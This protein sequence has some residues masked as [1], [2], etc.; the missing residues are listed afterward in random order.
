TS[1]A[2]RE[3]MNEPCVQSWKTMNVRVKNAEAG[4]TR[5]SD[6]QTDT[7]SAKVI[8]T[9]KAR[10]GTTEVARS[11]TLRPSRGFAYASRTPRHE[12][13]ES[14]PA[15]ASATAT[16]DVVAEYRC[17]GANAAATRRPEIQLLVPPDCRRFESLASRTC[18]TRKEPPHVSVIHRARCERA[19]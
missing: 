10:Y 15:G 7:R 9:S 13:D 6:S 14:V 3:R 1:F 11:S 2:R 8:A 12:R 19:R 5:A 18:F 16:R 17:Y 4:R